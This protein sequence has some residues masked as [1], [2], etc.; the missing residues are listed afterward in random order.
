[1][2]KKTRFSW[3]TQYLQHI[4]N[5]PQRKYPAWNNFEVKLHDVNFGGRESICYNKEVLKQRNM[6]LPK[7][8]H[9]YTKL[10][11][12]QDELTF[13]INRNGGFLLSN[14]ITAS[15]SVEE[16]YSTSIRHHSQQLTISRSSLRLIETNLY[17]C[18]IKLT[19]VLKSQD[20]IRRNSTQCWWHFPTIMSTCH[21]T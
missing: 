21:V 15:V 12:S 11:M 17:A 5:K 1:M 2:N 20:H 8:N 18:K 16:N 13:F 10:S 7:A 3:D 4:I 9:I 19:L 14:E 6:T